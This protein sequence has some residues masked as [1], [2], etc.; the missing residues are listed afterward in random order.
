MRPRITPPNERFLRHIDRSGGVDSCW[1]WTAAIVRGYG[2]FHVIRS[3]SVKA[4]RFAYE[5]WIG[6]IPEGMCVCHTCD[7]PRC[8]NPAHLWL[9]TNAE[10]T[11][12]KIAKG[13]A[14]YIGQY[15]PARGERNG[16][17]THPERTLRGES[18]H[19][20][21]LTAE[22]VRAIRA[23]YGT[24]TTSC[25]ELGVKYGVSNSTIHRIVR[26]T[27]WAHIE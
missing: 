14:R 3:K 23:D 26:R 22:L 20:S 10:N 15:N 18:Q 16:H 8:V 25:S 21:K 7:N 11:H 27:A 5:L 12:D 24:G 6:P 13:R 19:A 1:L 17:V 4:H 2:A 9:G